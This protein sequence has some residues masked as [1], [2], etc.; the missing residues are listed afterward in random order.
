MVGV[1]ILIAVVVLAVLSAVVGAV[2]RVG[3][4][5]QVRRAEA[6][7]RSALQAGAAGERQVRMGALAA[8]VAGLR[9]GEAS[10]LVLASRRAFAHE[11][12]PVLLGA[13]GHG[14]ATVREDA[15]RA[16]ADL[17][18]P[19]LRAAWQA[20]DAGRGGPAVQEFLLRHPDWL[21]E[22]LLEA[23]V[24][25]GEPAFRRHER[26]WRTG[27][28]RHRLELLRTGSDAVNALRAA[29]VGRLLGPGDGRAA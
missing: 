19:G 29:A 20:C 13:L 21:F 4:A 14:D 9:A 17:G 11:V 7:V 24:A 26:L 8:T 1:D 3:R 2:R 6:R 16:L 23:F 25:G 12:V 28:M 22:R 27:G 5:G 10:A 18:A 15:S